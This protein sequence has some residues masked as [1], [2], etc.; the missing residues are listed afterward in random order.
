MAT[1]TSFFIEFTLSPPPPPPPFPEPHTHTHTHTKPLLANTFQFFL[2]NDRIYTQSPAILGGVF[3]FF[4]F[5]LTILAVTQNS[6][7]STIT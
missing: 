6:L 2:Y 7:L 3:F 4:F 1:T 5:A